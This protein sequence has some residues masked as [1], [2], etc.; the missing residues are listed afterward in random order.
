[1]DDTALKRLADFTDYPLDYLQKIKSSVQEKALTKA[2]DAERINEINDFMKDKIGEDTKVSAETY[3]EAYKK[4]IG[5]GG[6]VTDFRYAYPVE[7]W[8]GTHEYKNLPADWQPKAQ[9]TVPDIKTLSADQQVFINQIQGKI[10]DG[11]LTYDEA[12]AKYPKVAVY[13]KPL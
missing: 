5:M 4:W 13:L 10:N 11:T 2:T 3:K 7:E 6:S 8:V 9:P 1:L 12:I